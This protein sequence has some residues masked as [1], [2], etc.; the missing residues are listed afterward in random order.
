M[1]NGNIPT[2]P[3]SGSPGSSML[4]S[5]VTAEVTCR[6]VCSV[7][8]QHLFHPVHFV[9]LPARCHQTV[10]CK[11]N[12]PQAGRLRCVWYSTLTC[13][14]FRTATEIRQFES[15]IR[16]LASSRWGF[17]LA[18]RIS[19]ANL[20]GVRF[21]TEPQKTRSKPLEQVQSMR[22]PLLPGQANQIKC[23]TLPHKR[24]AWSS[25]QITSLSSG[26][27]WRTVRPFTQERCCSAMLCDHMKAQPILAYSQRHRRCTTQ[28]FFH[29]WCWANG[30]PQ[31]SGGGVVKVSSL[32]V[33]S[34]SVVSLRYI[35]ARYCTTVCFLWLAFHLT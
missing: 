20:E 32:N 19:T 11:V 31:A 23:A 35:D 9:S 28:F 15:S 34:S 3:R 27:N 14:S 6:S 16:P 21:V 17:Y 1:H 10:Q 4:Q 7:T 8:R 2:A 22:K 12:Q 13:R 25:T 30:P 33:L 5:F 29:Q 26:S 24:M 18:D